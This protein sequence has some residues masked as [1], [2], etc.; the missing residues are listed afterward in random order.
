M[1]LVRA[2]VHVVDQSVRGDRVSTL[3]GI[4]DLGLIGGVHPYLVFQEDLV[5]LF[6]Y[7][8]NI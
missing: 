6:D 7:H 4:S 1:P 8:S 5:R 2:R 3:A